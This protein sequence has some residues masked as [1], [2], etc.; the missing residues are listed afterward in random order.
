MEFKTYFEIVKL[1]DRLLLLVATATT[2][3]LYCRCT[4][5]GNLWTTFKF[6]RNLVPKAEQVLALG[7]KTCLVKSTWLP[8][9]F[10]SHPYRLN[11]FSPGLTGER[12]IKIY[13]QIRLK[14]P[15]KNFKLNYFM[16]LHKSPTTK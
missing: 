3:S 11:G 4:L 6:L 14:T 9:H 1:S 16:F 8:D 15:I 10:I 13:R 12:I 5:S 2:R 7:L